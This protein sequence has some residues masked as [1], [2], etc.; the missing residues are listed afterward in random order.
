MK[1]LLIIVFGF[2]AIGAFAQD[3]ESAD[4]QSRESAAMDA[5]ATQWSFQLAYQMMPSY[6]DDLVNGVP[7]QF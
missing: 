5:T 1:K 6:Y 3:E 2:F 4:A 7:R